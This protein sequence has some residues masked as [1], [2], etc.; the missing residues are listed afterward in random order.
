MSPSRLISIIMTGLACVSLSSCAESATPSKGSRLPD[1]NRESGGAILLYHHVDGTTPPST[2]IDPELFG[3]HLDHL[4]GAGYTVWPLEKLINRVLANETTPERVVAITFDDAYISIY[5]T[6]FPLL[7]KHGFPFTIFVATAFVSGNS[8]QYLS[9]DQLAEMK[10]A[11]ATIANHSHSHAHL[12]RR[13]D[14]ESERQ[15]RQRVRSDI[16]RAQQL[17]EQH[18]GEAPR[19]FAYPYGEYDPMLVDI[20]E[21]LGFIGI[22]Q[23]SGAI[24]PTSWPLAIPR[25]PMGGSFSEMASFQTKVATRPLPMVTLALDPLVE[26]DEIPALT[27]DLIGDD[28]RG[29]QLVCYGPGNAVTA[30]EQ[31]SPTRF[32]ARSENPI[33]V[34]RS[35]YNCTMPDASGTRFYW[36]SQMWIKRNPD[37]TWYQED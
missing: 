4:A 32:V 21:D 11:G 37:G 13:L 10:A 29:H 24:G 6:A 20:V 12:V 8:N 9:W 1:L 22:G 33:P 2:S 19:L 36:Y 31:V 28:L 16:E 27:L 17:I 3:Q 5:T 23:Q 14:D 35:R 18:L 34:G 15:W 30:M 7:R 25:F 26:G